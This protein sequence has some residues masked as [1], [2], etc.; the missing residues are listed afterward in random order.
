MNSNQSVDIAN[1]LAGKAGEAVESAGAF[2]HDAVDELREHAEEALQEGE[3]CTR[4]HIASGIAT[5]FIGG[6]AI[7][8]L[9]ARWERPSLRKRYVDEPLSHAQDLALALAAP[10][11]MALRDRFD[12]A[13]SAASDA[14]SRISD[15]DFDPE[16]VFKGARRLGKRLKFW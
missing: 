13:R 8:L 10:L 6:L 5:A 11:A 3:D 1:G 14:A 7:G 16:P 12:H 9:L 2:A 15:L 4:R